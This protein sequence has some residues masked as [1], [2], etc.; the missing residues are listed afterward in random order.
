MERS[1]TH[2]DNKDVQVT[3]PEED[4]TVDNEIEVPNDEVVE[5]EVES[6]VIEDETNDSDYDKAWADID[7]DNPSEGLFGET[8]SEDTPDTLEDQQE[9]TDD[10]PIV[11]NQA[12]GLMIKNPILKF[13]GRDIPIE[14]EEEA[15]NLM[16]KGFKLE[17]EMTK[18][19]PYKQMIAILDNS[20][21]G[22]EDLK[23]FAD[24]MSGD[25]GAKTYIQKKLGL[26]STSEATSFFDEVDDQKQPVDEYK[27]E[28]PQTDAVADYFR[29][30]TENNPEVAG[31]VSQVYADIDDEFKNEVYTSQ[32]FPMF[33]SSI[34][35][36]EFDKLYP[37]AIKLKL[38]SPQST[39]LGAYQ[40]AAKRANGGKKPKTDV[41]PASTQ[42]PKQG[43]SNPRTT[44][45]D[46]DKAFSMDRQELED[47]IFG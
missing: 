39:W 12:T 6:P 9:V 33:V 24:A 41:P 22:T 32:M 44:G 43:A 42:I 23:A 17:S 31:K 34:A 4:V 47:R 7:T 8:L 5:N 15:I 28:V 46:Y 30:V 29:D 10:I 18:I 21:V 11:E 36:G 16:Q 2:L 38:A 27:P 13:K 25:E 1:T 37:M 14:S 19:K 3:P 40:E 20:T 45:S 35:S 26:Q